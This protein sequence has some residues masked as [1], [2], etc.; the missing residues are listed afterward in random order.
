MRTI[1]MYMYHVCTFV[2]GT[3]IC[4]YYSYVHV[5]TFVVG[6]GICAYYSYVCTFVVGTGICSYVGA[7]GCC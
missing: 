1:H 7:P 3:G 4:A 2:V 6:T 5:C